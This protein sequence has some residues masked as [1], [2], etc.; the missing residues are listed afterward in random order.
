ME[1]SMS[2]VDRVKDGARNVVAGTKNYVS[3]IAGGAKDLAIYATVGAVLLGAGA[4]VAE[5]VDINSFKDFVPGAHVKS[6]EMSLSPVDNLKSMVSTNPEQIVDVN[7]YWHAGYINYV[8][9]EADPEVSEAQVVGYS[10]N[11]FRSY[12]GI[13]G[14]L[15]GNY[16][17]QILGDGNTPEDV[18][19]VHDK[20][21]DGMGTAVNGTWYIGADDDLYYSG[22]IM[23]GANKIYGDVNELPM[24]VASGPI[25][26][27]PGMIIDDRPVR[28]GPAGMD[29]LF[30][31]T[32][33]W[34]SQDC[35][36]YDNN[37][38]DGADWNLDGKVNFVDFSH[39][40]QGWDPGYVAPMSAPSSPPLE[41]AVLSGG[42]KVYSTVQDEA[43][44]YVA[45]AV[46]SEAPYVGEPNTSY[47]IK[48]IKQGD[49]V[50]AT[51]GE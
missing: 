41:S 28:T 31:L 25:G 20:N 2:L 3:A 46:E 32:D 12:E 14:W 16:F 40:A 13:Q 36:P 22:D 51:F 30:Y 18:W 35:H 17:D 50:I 5:G 19:I 8:P 43:G 37:D 34:L 11:N 7:S 1:K 47:S 26:D 4:R 42:A 38:C 45:D 49:E 39:M 10:D 6:V 24:C 33:N 21:G 44:V 9:S 48:A 15:D 27:L 29:E 23:F